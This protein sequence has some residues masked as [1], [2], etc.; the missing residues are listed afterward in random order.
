MSGT[1]RPLRYA[2]LALLRLRLPREVAVLILCHSSIVACCLFRHADILRQHAL[3][4]AS[5]PDTRTAWLLCLRSDWTNG[6]RV[7]RDCLAF[8]LPPHSQLASK[9]LVLSDDTMELFDRER[10]LYPARSYAHVLTSGTNSR[11][12]WAV[13]WSLIEYAKDRSDKF[14][15]WY[16]DPIGEEESESEDDDEEEEE[17]LDAGGNAYADDDESSDEGERMDY[18]M[19]DDRVFFAHLARRASELGNTVMLERLCS[20]YAIYMRSPRRLLM[21]AMRRAGR[22]GVPEVVHWAV[23]VKMVWLVKVAM[24]AAAKYGQLKLM[25]HVYAQSYLPWT[26]GDKAH[27]LRTACKHGQAVVYRWLLDLDVEVG[28]FTL[29]DVAHSGD[30]DVVLEC[31]RRGACYTDDALNAAAAAG[32]RDMIQYFHQ[33]CGARQSKYACHAASHGGHDEAMLYLMLHQLDSPNDNDFRRLVQQG[34]LKSL[35][36]LAAHPTLV[37]AHHQPSPSAIVALESLWIKHCAGLQWVL[38]H[39][40]GAVAVGQH[41]VA[42]WLT[43]TARDAASAGRLH[44]LQL[45]IL[46]ENAISMLQASVEYNNLDIADWILQYFAPSTGGLQ[47]CL[48]MLHAHAEQLCSSNAQAS[49]FPA[50]Q[51]LVD[52]GCFVAP[53]DMVRAAIIG[54]SL[55]LLRIAQQH[56][57][58][59]T[60]R[61]R[62]QI[63]LRYYD[64]KPTNVSWAIALWP[65]AICLACV[66]EGFRESGVLDQSPSLAK[67]FSPHITQEHTC[68]AV[69]D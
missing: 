12:H 64:M 32:S 45:T 37:E 27:L 3:D 61:E 59:H 21:I 52:R 46:P 28:H 57:P 55:Q 24:D 39:L 2:L 42:D 48:D 8:Q 10:L 5:E 35:D 66:A 19:T 20:Q 1:L 23:Q 25:Q 60:I 69:S 36:Y 7:L 43:S 58:P 47:S 65:E 22:Y 40:D 68:S 11:R 33:H 17:E 51:W 34:C 62:L 41:G 16:L 49:S 56:L 63:F 54:R 26:D 29:A 31:A 4:Y 13:I 18:D 14:A 67:W 9:R 44:A 30:L 53:P 15:A 6:V 38:D 50:L